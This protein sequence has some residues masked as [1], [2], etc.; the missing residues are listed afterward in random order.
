MAYA[1]LGTPKPA[2]FD[3]SG[4]PLASG[5]LTIQ[6]PDDSSAKATYPTAVDADASTNGVSTAYTLDSRGE[7]ATQLWGR[8]G[9]DYKVILADSDAA[10]IYTIDEIRT[11]PKSRRATVTF[12]SA[13]GTP[14]V[15][16]GTLFITNGTTSITDFDDGQVGDIITIVGATGTDELV[17]TYNS[18]I[19]L[20]GNQ[21]WKMGDND[22]LTLAMFVDQVWQE[23][24]RKSEADGGGRTITSTT[25]VDASDSGTTFFLNHIDGFLTT[26]PSPLVGL[27]FKFIVK[28]APTTAYT[29][30]SLNGDNIMYGLLADINAT[31]PTQAVVTK[32]TISFVA[33]TS[34]IG[35]MVEF[36]SDGTNWYTFGFS[37]ADGGITATNT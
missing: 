11:P 37:S 28:T 20:R 22:T 25:T 17:I 18:N 13:D 30:R 15:A 26:L 4:A 29:I 12:D 34:P 19:L 16:D 33:S 6:D 2:F 10:N 7:I 3:S 14:S 31:A 5:T 32:D 23:I 9:E 27:K 21:N 24:G 35:D 8:D 1:I 36:E